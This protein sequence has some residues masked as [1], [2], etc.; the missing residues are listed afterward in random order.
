M[1]FGPL[2]LHACIRNICLLY[3]LVSRENIPPGNEKH[4]YRMFGHKHLYITLAYSCDS[5]KMNENVAYL[6]FHKAIH[7]PKMSTLL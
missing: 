1:C 5:N 2:I 6:Y 7:H 3:F 4:V